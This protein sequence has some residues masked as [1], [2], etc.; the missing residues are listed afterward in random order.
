L[1]QRIPATKERMSKVFV[2][3]NRHSESATT[4]L[5]TDLEAL[6]HNVWLDQELSG[7]QVWWEKILGRIRDCDVFVFVIEPRSLTS[8]ACTREC[9]YASALGKPVLPVLVADGVS[10]NLLRPELAQRQIIDYRTP[11]RSTAFRLA[12]A[13]G[14]LPVAVPLPSPLPSSPE[15][16]LS[17]LSGIAKRVDSTSNLSDDEQSALTGHLRRALRDRE[18]ADDAQVLLRRLRKRRDLLVSIAEEIDELL[19]QTIRPVVPQPQTHAEPPV[20][21]H[22][23]SV[24]RSLATKSSVSPRKRPWSAVDILITVG[25]MALAIFLGVLLSALIPRAFIFLSPATY[26]NDLGRPGDALYKLAGWAIFSSMASVTVGTI[27]R[28]RPRTHFA[29]LV[30]LA[31][32]LWLITKS[33]VLSDSVR[34]ALLP[35][36]LVVGTVIGLSVFAS[37]LLLV[38]ERRM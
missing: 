9:D 15:V 11:D 1:W 5:V 17:Y 27:V 19:E 10:T 22:S 13:F 30:G 8:V 28:F 38:V 31:V 29:I 3:Y 2:S 35:I 36:S 32:V 25:L 18:N 4:D 34:I 21:I 26:A 16:P 6:G 23:D 33:W 7:G 37:W 24:P 14:D 12:R 20:A